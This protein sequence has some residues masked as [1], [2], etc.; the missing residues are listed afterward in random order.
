MVGVPGVW[1]KGCRTCRERKIKVGH[2]T[3]STSPFCYSGTVA[4]ELSLTD[5]QCDQ[6]R[7]R[8]GQCVRSS[9]ECPGYAQYNPFVNHAGPATFEHTTSMLIP[10]RTATRA[11]TNNTERNLEFSW[12]DASDPE[13][14]T[15]RS[16]PWSSNQPIETNDPIH[17][18][19]QSQIQVLHRDTGAKMTAYPRTLSRSA[20][21][22]LLIDRFFDLYYPQTIWSRPEQQ[23]GFLVPHS[24]VVT[25]VTQ[26]QFE[27]LRQALLAICLTRVGQSTR[28]RKLVEQSMRHYSKALFHL[29]KLLADEKSAQK[30]ATALACLI[31]GM[32]EVSS[33]HFVSIF[34]ECSM[35]VISSV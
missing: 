16:T 12:D 24:E 28:D 30:D 1:S 19:R 11:P 4:L 34:A 13:E 5:F 17:A 7:S 20:F 2:D 33:V 27:P 10:M 3:R 26:T 22:S 29:N 15:L 35:G 25:T 18:R 32:Y 31:C 9:R 21:E 14:K 6:Q 8:C 23:F